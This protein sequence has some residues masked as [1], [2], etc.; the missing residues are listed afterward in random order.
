[1]HTHAS[2]LRQRAVFVSRIPA[3]HAAYYHDGRFLLCTCEL[4]SQPNSATITQPD[5]PGARP[6]GG[7]AENRGGGRF[8]KRTGGHRVR[9]SHSRLYQTPFSPL[10]R[11]GAGRCRRGLQAPSRRRRQDAGHAGR[12]DEHGRAWPVAGR[13]DP[14]G[15]GARDLLH[16]RQSRGRH[17][18]P[19]RARF[20]RARAELPRSDAR[21]TSRRCSSAT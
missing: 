3:R 15:Q 4:A 1:M 10:Q 18:Q 13:D 5:A 20:L 2:A 17:F 8:F 7:W 21:R 16:R 9:R 11:G 12:R 19:R 14:P 6:T